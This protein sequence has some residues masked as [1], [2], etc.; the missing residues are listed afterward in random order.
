MPPPEIPPRN[1]TIL[2]AASPVQGL[3]VINVSPAVIEELKLRGV[4]DGVVVTGV[5]RGSTARRLG[6]RKGDVI[7]QINGQDIA[8]I[9]ELRLWEGRDPSVWQIYLRRTGK[10]LKMEFRG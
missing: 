8:L 3:R 5:R 1:E 7:Q 9:K 6:F 4:D 2:S 10:R